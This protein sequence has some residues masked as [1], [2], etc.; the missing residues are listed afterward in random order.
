MMILSSSPDWF[1][2][3]FI[4]PEIYFFYLSVC[5][6]FDRIQ[7]QIY[8]MSC[9]I[10]YLSCPISNVT[11]KYRFLHKISDHKAIFYLPSSCPLSVLLLSS[12]PLLGCVFY[13]RV[14]RKNCVFSKFAATPPSPYIAVRD[15]LSS[16]RNAS[17]QPLLLAGNFLYNQQQTS[18][19]VG[20]VANFWEFLGKNTICNEHPVAL[21]EVTLEMTDSFCQYNTCTSSLLNFFLHRNEAFLPGYCPLNDL[22]W[23]AR[24]GG[25]P[26]ASKLLILF[27][28]MHKW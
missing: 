27:L 24:G 25:T 26:L 8:M 20:E 18:A 10:L 14:L 6:S 21:S 1:R 5:L 16:Q 2:S 28:S 13:Y 15:L 4:G 9:P 3:P 19:S 11:E 22:Q 23:L 12:C 7:P 17:V